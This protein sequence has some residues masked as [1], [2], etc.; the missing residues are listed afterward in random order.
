MSITAS[1]GNEEIGIPIAGEVRAIDDT[2]R[3]TEAAGEIAAPVAGR[4]FELR[5]VAA[6]ERTDIYGGRRQSRRRPNPLAAVPVESF[7]KIRGIIG[8]VHVLD[9]HLYFSNRSCDVGI[10][11]GAGRFEILHRVPVLG[12]G[13]SDGRPCL[14]LAQLHQRR[15][16]NEAGYSHQQRTRR[17][18]FNYS[19]N[20]LP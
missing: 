12:T 4:I 20:F 1:L 15:Q 9:G 3:Q 10:I 5:H 17:Q 8:I 7:A 6:V 18:R 13:K 11:G 14:C 2:F 16:A 19:H